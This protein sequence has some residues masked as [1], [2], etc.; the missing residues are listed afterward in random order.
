MIFPPVV[1]L[2][3]KLNI[4]KQFLSIVNYIHSNLLISGNRITYNRQ[5]E[6]WMGPQKMFV[7]C[8]DNNNNT[9][10]FHFHSDDQTRYRPT[11][12]KD[13]ACS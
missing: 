11:L 3:R 13:I 7:K 8:N 4:N 9:N 2:L 12:E 6:A 1:S 10:T 5:L